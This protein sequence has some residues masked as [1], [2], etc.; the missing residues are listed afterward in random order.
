MPSQGAGGAPGSNIKKDYS[1]QNQTLRAF[2]IKQ[3]SDAQFSPESDSPVVDG[4]DVSNFTIVARVVA[5]EEQNLMYVYR[6]DDGTGR[7]SVKYWISSEGDDTAARARLAEIQPGSYV[8]C[9]GH[10]Q[11]FQSERSMVAFNIRPVTDF[12]EV[13][14][15]NL[16]AIM[17]HLHLTRG[18]AGGAPAAIAGAAP[19]GGYGAPAA[20]A[21]PVAGGFGDGAS[22]LS[23]IQ[24]EI[25]AVFTAPDAA[26][27]EVGISIDQAIG[28]CGNKFTYAQ[29][30]DAVEMLQNEGL[31]YSTVDDQHY[32]SCMG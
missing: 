27:A 1:K 14:Y 20:V 10:F 2:T 19:V 7:L 29:V 30:R 17:Q 25:L 21:P 26:G 24:Q 9:H 32:K 22:G 6:V 15:H 23:A 12:N 31:L 28:R 4:K 16:Q 8:R 18:G 11:S 3:L 5:V 13:T